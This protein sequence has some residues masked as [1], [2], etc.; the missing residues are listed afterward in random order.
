MADEALRR[1]YPE[2]DISL[3]LSLA[4]KKWP[5]CKGDDRRREAALA[6]YLARRGFS[7]STVVKVLSEMRDARAED[8][9]AG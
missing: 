4:W 8:D 9:G 3:A 6:G 2:E 5:A 7:T 1:L